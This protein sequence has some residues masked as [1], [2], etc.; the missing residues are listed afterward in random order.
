MFRRYLKSGR[1]S[2]MGHYFLASIG[3]NSKVTFLIELRMLTTNLFAWAH[4][5][6][7]VCLF[8]V[9]GTELELTWIGGYDLQLIFC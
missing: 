5:H 3:D 9:L 8:L 2:T 4:A 7:L 6:S 1:E